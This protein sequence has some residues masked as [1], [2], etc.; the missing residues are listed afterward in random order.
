MDKADMK[1]T[2]IAW[3]FDG[4]L[5]DTY[6]NLARIYEE[7]LSSFGFKAANE[8]IRSYLAISIGYA[9][10]YYAEKYG[11]D[12]KI[13][14]RRYTEQREQNGLC[15]HEMSL[16]PGVEKTLKAIQESGR[17]NHLYTNRNQLAIRYLEEFNILQ[18]FDG[19]VTGE[20]MGKLKP[21]PDGMYVLY[22]QY[23]ILPEKM[24]MVGD[25][26]VDI[27][28]AK[29]AGADACFYNTNGIEIPEGTDFE[30]KDIEELLQYL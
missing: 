7:T 13:L 8:E 14:G 21:A 24:L 29:A 1:Y 12:C 17:R 11:I 5:I 30:I 20:N 22:Q 18:Y 3:D 25:R 16:Y 27:N 4:T 15:F 26:A 9:H 10:K 28:A 19:F 2:D 6:P 23:D